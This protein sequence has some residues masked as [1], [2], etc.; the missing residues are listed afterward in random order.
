MVKKLFYHK[1]F[2]YMN[3]NELFEEIQDK[4][5]PDDLKGEFTLHGNCIVWTYDLDNDSE[6]IDLPDDD[7]EESF[8]FEA[9]SPEELLLE[10]HQDDLFIFEGLLDEIEE[11]GNWSYSEPEVG[12]K[13]ISFRIF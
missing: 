4:I 3:I 10:A 5:Y 13:V 6:E 1:Y 12:E 8:G 11:T 7:D 2:M 9:L